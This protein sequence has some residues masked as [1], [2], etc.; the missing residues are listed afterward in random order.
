MTMCGT[1]LHP[2]SA[3][4]GLAQSLIRL[5]ISLYWP[6]LISDQIC[7]ASSSVI[8]LDRNLQHPGLL[9]TAIDLVTPLHCAY[10]LHT[11][12]GSLLPPLNN[13][14]C[15]EV[16][17]YQQM[18]SRNSFLPSTPPTLIKPNMPKADASHPGSA[19]TATS[20][21]ATNEPLMLAWNSKLMPI[22]P[23]RSDRPACSS[24]RPPPFN[25]S[26]P[27]SWVKDL[28]LLLVKDRSLKPEEI[29]IFNPGARDNVEVFCHHIQDLA[30]FKSQAAI[31]IVLMQC[32]H[33]T[34]MDWYTNLGKI[35]HA[36]LH[37]STNAWQCLCDH[38]SM[39]MTEAHSALSSLCYDLT[40]DYHTYHKHKICLACIAGISVPKQI[41]QSLFAGLPFDMRNALTSSL[42]G[43][44]ADDL[45]IFCCCCLVQ[46]AMLLTCHSEQ[47]H[48]PPPT[49]K[50]PQPSWP[51]QQVTVMGLDAQEAGGSLVHMEGAQ[52]SKT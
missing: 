31:C 10:S 7:P 35:E 48:M 2:I 49:F 43:K 50:T 28:T 47:H 33:L 16:L 13:P 26:R 8:A 27:S 17:P 39:S 30:A 38:F 25:S 34:A 41:V 52:V 20:A 21:T 18:S 32:L 3:E 11:T 44:E 12:R 1:V 15:P 37:V 9:L 14:D 29:A 24:N 36:Q 46:C 6:C 4:I 42:E 45:N 40:G 22:A 5:V 19:H 51:Q 23:W